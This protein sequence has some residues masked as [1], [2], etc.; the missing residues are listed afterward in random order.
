MVLVDTSVW[1]SHLKGGNTRLEIL[2]EEAQVVS[3]P[4]VMGELACGNLKNRREILTRLEALPQAPLVSPHE[5]LYFI[6]SNSLMGRGLGWVDV[7]LLASAQLMGIALWTLD[8]RLRQ[9]ADDLKLCYIP[10]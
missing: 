10:A 3:H 5:I 7:H 1:I 2:L 4:F 6:E 8:R 9:T